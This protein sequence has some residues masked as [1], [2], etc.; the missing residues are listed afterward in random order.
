MA[1]YK[2]SVEKTFP[3]V[4][5]KEL[6]GK[7]EC[8]IGVSMGNP[9]YWRS[10]LKTILEWADKNFE[11]STI[12][13]GDLLYRWNDLIYN[14][15]SL[16]NAEKRCL[17]LGDKFIKQYNKHSQN[18]CAKKFTVLRWNDLLKTEKFTKSIEN[19]KNAYSSNGKFKNEIN[20]QARAFVESLIVRN[21]K[22]SLEVSKAIELSANYLIE[23]LAVFSVLMQSS[24]VLVY[25]GTT[26]PLLEAMSEGEYKS[27]LPNLQDVIY[28]QLKVTKG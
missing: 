7:K 13:V 3:A 18:I 21:K 6:S 9:V 22:M 15:D 26:L 12:L 25:P 20:E 11:K 5:D 4:S 1:T 23:E 2:L 28:L 14:N 16:T 17:K 8:I 24:S 10:S 27:I 19:L